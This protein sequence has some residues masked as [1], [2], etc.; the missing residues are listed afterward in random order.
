MYN[1]KSAVGIDERIRQGRDRL[2]APWQFKGSIR[3]VGEVVDVQ[4]IDPVPGHREPQLV[5][6]RQGRGVHRQAVAEKLDRRVL[7]LADR[8]FEGVLQT[9]A[10]ML[11]AGKCD[12]PKV[13]CQLP[14]PWK[15]L[16]RARLS[17]EREPGSCEK[18]RAGLTHLVCE[19]E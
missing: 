16:A 1:L 3:C 17:V 5:V 10:V 19:A 2:N 14:G 7:P 15:P 4:R 6:L 12:F 11:L 9:G 13:A 8:S 18:D